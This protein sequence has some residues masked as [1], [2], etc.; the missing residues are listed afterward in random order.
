MIAGVDISSFAIDI[1]LLDDDTDDAT[2]HHFA[3]RGSTPFERARNA[4][5][6]L[7]GRSWWED[8]GVWLLGYEDPVGHHA[9]TAKALGLALGAVAVLLP[10]SL[11]CVATQASEWQ[12]KFTGWK[13]QPRTS[14]E[15]KE[16]VRCRADEL[17]FT[18]G[19]N[20]NATDAYGIAW[21]IRSLN[22]AA[23]QKGA[24]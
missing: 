23:I 7:P 1:V 12:R 22:D 10:P 13:K 15:R 11:V 16:L 14:A 3:L 24:A 6:V 2:W 18:P 17:G 8:C 4:R 9:H 20:S 5:L 19:K 21:V